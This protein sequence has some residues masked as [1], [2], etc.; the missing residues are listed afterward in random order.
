MLIERVRRALAPDYQVLQEVAGG[1]MGI[2]YTA[3]HARLGRIVAIKVLRPELATAVAAERF[4]DEGRTLARIDHPAVVT[5]YDAGEKDGLFYYAMEFVEGETLSSRLQ[6]GPLP[7]AEVRLL[8]HDLLG[9]LN[10][11]HAIGVVHRDVKPA[12]VF[13]RNGR[14]LLGDFGMARWR[15]RTDPA[16]TTPGQL[17]GTVRYMAPEQRDGL[18]AT[19]RTDVYAAALVLWEASTGERWPAD[20]AP[21]KADWKR[22]P[23]P[24]AI[25]LRRALVLEPEGRFAN[26]GEFLAALPAEPASRWRRPLLLGGLLAAATLAIAVL[27]WLP[28]SPPPPPVGLTLEVEP[29]EVRGLPGGAFRDSL[30]TA[31]ISALSGYPDLRVRPAGSGPRTR[32][33]VRLAGVMTPA[34]G[35]L[36][37]E[38]RATGGESGGVAAAAADAPS[39]EDWTALV[40]QVADSFLA[41]VW[42]GTLAGDHWLPLKALPRTGDGLS[43]WHAAEG[44]YAQAR[45]NE[46]RDAYARIELADTSCTLC[47]YRLIDIDRW[48]TKP[49][50]PQRFARLNRHLDAFPPHYTAIIRAQQ[51]SWPARYDSLRAAADRYQEFFLASFLLGDE[52][53]HRGPLYGHLRHEALE[54]LQHALDLRPDFTPGWEHLSWVLLSEGTA[55]EARRALDSVSPERAAAGLSREIRMMLQL[56]YLWRFGSTAEAS[57]ATSTALQMPAVAGDYRTTSGGRMMMTV[58]A[59]AGAV[60]L[61]AQLAAWR[62]KPEAVRAGLLA[63]AHGFAALGRLDS[64]RAVGLRLRHSASNHALALYAL[65]LEA[66]HAL[67]DADD[68]VPV[69]PGLI[70]A[71][72]TYV[73]T[74][75]EAEPLRQRAA[76]LLALLALRGNDS[77]AAAGYRGMLIEHPSQT[78]LGE[79]VDLFALLRR[80]DTA[81]AG[82]MLAGLPRSDLSH[83]APVP[84]EDA[85]RRLL[86]AAWLERTGA[87]GPAEQEL[88]WHEHLQLDGFPTGDPQAG[89]AAWALGT[90]LRWRRARI[91]DRRGAADLELCAAY[92]A[93]A[94]LW[95]GA[96]PRL[97][98]RAE[99]AGRRAA[100]LKCEGSA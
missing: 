81:R 67:A 32:G 16:L 52:L 65:E 91:L 25:P 75:A 2:V 3:R 14:A 20:Q 90:L 55:A 68:S 9:A 63:Q 86:R 99:T 41:E 29:F 43:R 82:R 47:T 10:A 48:L 40:R 66:V 24:M 64:L 54:P 21:E 31:L 19:E 50:D 8:A 15:A 53:F 69:D 36:R 58:D 88:R 45:W 17:I 84:L 79:E 94:R 11:A 59:P 78:T 26:A 57:V 18:E 30:T 56:G 62:G 27:R 87:A 37:L 38:L 6:R 28:T 35:G 33:A 61:G 44:L 60:G 96:E 93:V 72:R 7:A 73:A 12:N 23:P 70:T 85:V 80:G 71:L 13:L 100:Q 76:W 49:P 77:A 34:G 74:G 46:A 42:R 4:A 92:Q 97:A 98:A 39:R 83:I 95:S 1:G 5:V 22:L 89:E 51:Q